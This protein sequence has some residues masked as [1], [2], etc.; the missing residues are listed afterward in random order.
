MNKKLLIAPAALAAALLFAGC[1]PAAEEP[2]A[3]E[4]GVTQPETMPTDTGEVGGTTDP[5]ATDPAAMDPAIS[6]S[7]DGMSN[8]PADFPA[9]IPVYG[10]NALVETYAPVD[11][12]MEIAFSG[13]PEDVM[14]LIP[15]FEA[16]GFI[17]SGG[18]VM[19]AAAKTEYNIMIESDPANLPEGAAYKYVIFPN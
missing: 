9:G 17:I 11:G 5:G 15:V 7:G 13:T 2:A 16:N 14:N 4:P 1:T 19:V 12:G 3:T 10:D 18:D 6:I 8:L